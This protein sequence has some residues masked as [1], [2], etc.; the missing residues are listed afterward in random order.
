MTE[1]FASRNT[2]DNPVVRDE[3]ES[4][5]SL[6]TE[7]SHSLWS[8]LVAPPPLQPPDWLRSRIRRLFLVSLGVPVDLDE[9]LPASKQ[10]KL[11]LPS[12]NFEVDQSSSGKGERSSSA[13][14]GHRQSKDKALS[15]STVQPDRSDRKR[16]GAAAIPQFDTSTA[17]LLCSKTSEALKN[18]TDEE[19]VS[20]VKQ[21]EELKQGAALALE[22][23]LVERDNAQGDKEAFEEVIENL[24]KHAKKIRK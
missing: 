7:R 14:N 1:L 22:Y 2:P 19:L 16:R 9:I 12:I 20:H 21:L 15:S 24:V 11:V 3:T 5:G 10:K 6:L 8:Q 17:R 23:W 4:A 18:L 13:S